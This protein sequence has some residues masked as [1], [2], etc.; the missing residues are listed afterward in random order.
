MADATFWQAAK[1]F[2]SC[3]RAVAQARSFSDTDPLFRTGMV[4]DFTIYVFLICSTQIAEKTLPNAC[5][6]PVF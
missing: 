4:S 5:F 6:Q 2:Q 3:F 1:G